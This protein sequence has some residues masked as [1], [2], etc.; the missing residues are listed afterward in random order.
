[1]AV[2]EKHFCRCMGEG[3]TRD[4]GQSRSKAVL[5]NGYKWEPGTT[6]SIRFLGGDAQLQQRVKAVAKEW[7]EFANLTFKF[8][9]SGAADIRIAFVE[10]NGSW[11][12]IGTMCKGIDES[13]PTMNFGWL[14]ADSSDE[15]L[16]SVVLHEFGHALGLIHEHQSPNDG[17]IQWNTDAV[18][19]DLSG[20]PNYWDKETIEENMFKKYSENE[21]VM[22]AVDP[23]SIMM[24]PIP[25]SWTLDGTTAGFNSSLSALDKQLIKQAYFR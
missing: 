11:S 15:V 1:M 17:G 19:A 13:Q 5:L 18:V 12:Y 3:I 10:G 22:T 7:L 2:N 14:T 9:Q 23:L 20:P 4:A 24:Y 16:R 6:L 21:V 25:L 8:L